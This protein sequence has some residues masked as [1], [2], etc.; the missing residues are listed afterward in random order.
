MNTFN[1]T[2]SLGAILAG[3]LVLSACQSTPS[4][5]VIQRAN[6]IYETTGIADTKVK[7]Q[8]NAIDSAQKTCRS[9]QVMIVDDNVKYNGILNERTGRM[10]GQVGSVVGS[11][12]G[13]GTPDLSRNDDYEYK[14]NFRCQ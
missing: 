10:V 9:K 6:S 11:I 2:A 13:T 14:I 3:A 8:Q 12:F 5:P 4:S 7:A 1:K